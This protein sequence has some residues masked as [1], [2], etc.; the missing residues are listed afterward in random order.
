MCFTV[1]RLAMHAWTRTHTHMRAY[2]QST[3]TR[4]HKANTHVHTLAHMCVHTHTHTR[5]QNV[6]YFIAN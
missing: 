2:T 5:V 6:V 4:A 3:H 1:G